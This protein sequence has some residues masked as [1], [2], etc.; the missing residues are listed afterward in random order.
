[1]N[2]SLIAGIYFFSTGRH[3]R[4][5]QTCALLVEPLLACKSDF[6]T[7]FNTQI[8]I[9]NLFESVNILNAMLKKGNYFKLCDY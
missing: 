6:N 4:Q 8:M 9:Q 5:S 3:Q 2:Y 1:M 7:R